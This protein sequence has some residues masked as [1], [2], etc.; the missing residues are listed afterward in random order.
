MENILS[1][2]PPKGTAVSKRYAVAY[3]MSFLLSSRLYC[4]LRI[5]TVSAGHDA[6]RPTFEYSVLPLFVLR[7]VV[8][9]SLRRVH[10][11]LR[12]VSVSFTT[13][14]EFHPAPKNFSLFTYARIPRKYRKIKRFIWH[15][16]PLSNGVVL[17]DSI[18]TQFVI[19]DSFRC[20][21]PQANIP[22][23]QF[24]FFLRPRRYLDARPYAAA[25]SQ[26]TRETISAALQYHGSAK[27][28]FTES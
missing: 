22:T 13:S 14:R 4:W 5:L 3:K 9:S 10:S 18:F 2:I 16:P 8:D 25:Q 21:M 6:F 19:Q 12:I 20:I 7:R 15:E 23:L 17:F 28:T 1:L 24:S 27:A 26:N 11:F